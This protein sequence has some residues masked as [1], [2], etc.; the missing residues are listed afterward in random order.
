ME[1]SGLDD[2][3]SDDRRGGGKVDEDGIG[4]RKG[5]RKKSV[6][7]SFRLPDRGAEEG[8]GKGQGWIGQ[9]AKAKEKDKNGKGKGQ[10]QGQ[11]WKGQNG[12]RT[13]KQKRNEVSGERCEE[14]PAP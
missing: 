13:V 10:R 5:G 4:N 7:F 2:Q 3:V 11:G 1:S 9:K 8:K 14:H 12:R 6:K